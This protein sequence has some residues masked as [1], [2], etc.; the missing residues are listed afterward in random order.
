MLHFLNRYYFYFFFKTIS[1]KIILTISTFSMVKTTLSYW[2]IV[3]FF[4]LQNI[5]SNHSSNFSLAPVGFQ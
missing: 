2:V 1:E 3:L 4:D 5:E